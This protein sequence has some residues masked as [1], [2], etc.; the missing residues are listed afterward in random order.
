[1]DISK[2]RA[3]WPTIDWQ[4]RT[5]QKVNLNQ[6]LLSG[7]T[8]H[9]NKHIPGLTSL[10]IARHGFLAFEHYA[11]GFTRH[12]AHYPAS[13]VKSVISALVGI[14]LQQKRIQHLDQTLA[15]AFPASLLSQVEQNRREITL[16]SLLTMTSGLAREDQYILKFEASKNFVSAVLERSRDGIQVLC[17]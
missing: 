16:R 6:A 15:E 14:A 10:L 5:P 17:Q 3:Y 12:D 9:I 2:Q 13:V 8:E 4:E 1:M 11:Q 7:M